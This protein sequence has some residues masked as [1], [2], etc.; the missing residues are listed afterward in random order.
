[1]KTYAMTGGAT[2][3]GAEIKN[4]LLSDGHEVIVID[5]KNAN[6]VADLSTKEGRQAA[7][8]AL[9]SQCVDGIDGFIACAGLGSHI[10]NRALITA[11]NYFGTVQLVEQ[12]SDLI[13]KKRGSVL[14]ISSNSAPMPTNNQYV[15]QLLDGDEQAASKTSEDMEGQQVYSGTKQA[16]ARWM[17]HNIERFANRG[18]RINAIAP[19]YTQTP[20][21]Q[22]IEEDPTYSKAIKAFMESIPVGRPGQSKDMASAAKFLLSEDASFVCGSVLFVDGGHDA[23]ARPDSF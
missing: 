16:I 22:Q 14:L 15:D 11:V 8:D 6:I 10:P 13:A 7:I 1:M 9:Y 18:I 21:T 3:I 4:Q 23:V 20:M 12:L 19:G 17:R 5:I 2:G